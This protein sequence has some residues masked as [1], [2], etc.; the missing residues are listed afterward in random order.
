MREAPEG[1]STVPRSRSRREALLRTRTGDPLLTIELAWTCGKV[2]QQARSGVF[3]GAS[4]ASARWKRHSSISRFCEQWAR[5]GHDR[6]C[7]DGQ[8]LPDSRLQERG[9]VLK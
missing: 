3:A 7:Q 6:C 4:T 5:F 8:A 2:S 1:T 9:E